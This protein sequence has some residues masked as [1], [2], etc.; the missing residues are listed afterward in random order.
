ML[1]QLYESMLSNYKLVDN[2]LL[3]P[4]ELLKREEKTIEIDLF[5]N[6]LKENKIELKDRLMLGLPID[7]YEY[8]KVYVK[9]KKTLNTIN[10]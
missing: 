7:K 8:Y 4:I 6:I 1:L 2:K 5:Y 10:R 3:S 9:K